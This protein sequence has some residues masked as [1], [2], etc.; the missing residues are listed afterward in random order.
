MFFKTFNPM[1]AEEVDKKIAAVPKAKSGIPLSGHMK[2]RSFQLKFEGE[3]AP[4]RLDYRIHDADTLYVAEN[5]AE[6]DRVPYSAIKFGEITL[7]THLIPGTSRGWHIVLDERTELVTAFE[8]WFGISVPVGGDLFGMRQ[9]THYRDI[10][11][12][13]QRHY[14]FGYAVRDGGR[15]RDSVPGKLHTTTNRLE[16]RGL[17]WKYS[18]G[19]EVLTYFPSVVCST[20][21]ML[22]DPR[23]TVTVTY[24]S[25]YLRIDDEYY[26]YAKWG[27]EFAGEMWLE[28]LNL[29]DM[30][31]TGVKLGFNE[32]DE[33]EYEIHGA[34]LEITGDAAHLETIT[35][36]GDKEPPMAGMDGRGARYAY[37][38][39]D[40]DPPMTHE[41]V[42]EAAKT[43]RIFDFSGPNI[44][45]SGNAL[46]FKYDLAGKT[47]KLIYDH[48]QTPY[49]W[50]AKNTPDNLITQY[51]YDICGGET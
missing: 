23:D 11:R 10:P 31:A 47:F 42:L 17:H 28:V 18:C 3:H 34:C 8:T 22:D 4:K 26:I 20:N 24:P 33:P 27:V 14:H 45:M 43:Q 35:L 15:Y 6:F 12:E 21:V 25:D 9:P 5:G 19:R 30:K 29:F 40:I 50:S 2:G 38:P 16:G 41:E 46:P 32:D 1:T 39:R 49:A 44:M 37:R 13:I 7:F 36:N 51:E 48:V